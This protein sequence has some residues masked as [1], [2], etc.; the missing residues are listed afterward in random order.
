MNTQLVVNYDVGS[1]YT[2]RKIK[3]D[4]EHNNIPKATKATM[5]TAGCDKEEVMSAIP[6]KPA[7]FET[8]HIPGFIE[9][10]VVTYFITP[11]EAIGVQNKIKI[12]SNSPDN[13]TTTSKQVSDI[14]RDLKR[15]YDN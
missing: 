14:V 13:I 2:C 5:F 15:N 3:D 12:S 4:L 7:P 9:V 1:E 11:L 6:T 10:S 8:L